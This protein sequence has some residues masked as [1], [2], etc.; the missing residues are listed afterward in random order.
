MS[1][2]FWEDLPPENQAA[3]KKAFKDAGDE[4]M[5]P[6]RRVSHLLKALNLHDKLDL[7]VY[8]AGKHKTTLGRLKDGDL[9][10]LLRADVERLGVKNTTPGGSGAP[11][12]MEPVG[13][14]VL[15]ERSVH[16]HG[17]RSYSLDNDQPIMV[18]IEED[19]I[20]R[21]FAA[22]KSALG[23]KALEEHVENVSRVMN[24][25]SEK[26]PGAVRMPERRGDGYFIRVE[27]VQPMLGV[28]LALCS[29]VACH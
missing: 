15:A 10:A 23:T 25:L 4:I 2:P 7:K 13:Q 24:R 11:T 29:L 20:L 21:A 14:A 8:L 6:M 5:Q 1:K 17:N 9:E 16:S 19:S 3:A 27:P 26:F 28:S 12:P 22:A 18:S